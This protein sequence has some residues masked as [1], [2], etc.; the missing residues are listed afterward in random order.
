MSRAE[1]SL[2]RWRMSLILE[3]KAHDLQVASELR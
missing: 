2:C 3:G 1:S